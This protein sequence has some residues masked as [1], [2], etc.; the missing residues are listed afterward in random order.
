MKEF[1]AFDILGPIM[2]GPSSSHTAGAVRL[3]K[4]ASIISEENNPKKVTFLLHGSFS[5]TYRGHG[6]DK[7]LV[8]GILG[9][10]PWDVRIRE[11][12]EIAKKNGIDFE[13]KPADLGDVHPNT[14]KFLIQKKNNETVEIMGSSTGGGNIKIIEINGS[15]VEFT[16]AYP[17][18]IVSHKDVPGMI[19]KITTMIYE[20]NINIAFLKV[21][22]SSRGFAAKMIVETDTVIDKQIIDKMKQIE[23]LKSVIV[24]NPVIEGE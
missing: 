21:Y 3:G 8:A 16:G 11:S 9:M 24:I 15:S 23:N 20:N 13:F 7:A 12:F 10:E 19:S 1:S 5:E 14:V 2:I 6:T 17:T 22:R 4:I 18:L